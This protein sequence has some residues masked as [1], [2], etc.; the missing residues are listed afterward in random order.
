M[1]PRNR[2]ERWELRQSPGPQ[3][4]HIAFLAAEPQALG[5]TLRA[6]QLPVLTD[7]FIWTH[8]FLPPQTKAPAFWPRRDRVMPLQT[9]PL[10]L[11]SLQRRRVWRHPGPLECRCR[12]QERASATHSLVVCPS[13]AGLP[14]PTLIFGQYACVS[15][16]T[17]DK[18]K[19][20]CL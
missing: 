5:K 8:I 6:Q 17:W 14:P 3:Q 11:G 9:L 16:N 7:L 1:K 10:L 19:P 12:H 13:P 4:E 20:S 15:T 18:D 2:A